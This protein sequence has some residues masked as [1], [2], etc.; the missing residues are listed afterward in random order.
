MIVD[1]LSS[2]IVFIYLC[3]KSYRRPVV[4]FALFFVL[5]F[6]FWRLLS[7]A[8]VSSLE[9]L[10]PTE[11]GNSII[12]YNRYSG[13]AFAACIFITSFAWFWVFSL[14]K[15][16]KSQLPSNTRRFSNQ[17]SKTL[18]E[19]FYLACIFFVIGLFISLF[20]IGIIPLFSGME[21]F[22]YAENHAGILHQFLFSHGRAG[23]F[24]MGAF[25]IRPVLENKMPDGRF[26]FLLGIILFYAFI[27]GHRFSGFFQFISFFILPS[28]LFFLIN[29]ELRKIIIKKIFPYIS[30]LLLVL[31]LTVIY[32]IL[33]SYLNVRVSNAELTGLEALTERLF[34]QPVHLWWATWDRLLDDV[35]QPA[36]AI[37]FI[38]STALVGG[39]NA[40]IQYLMV[41]ELGIDRAEELLLQGTQLQGGYPE[42][43][44]EV[45]GIYYGFIAVFFTALLVAYSAKLIVL[46]FAAG[47]VIATTAALYVFQ[48]ISLVI[49]GGMI[50]FFVAWTYWVKVSALILAMIFE[51]SIYSYNKLKT[52]HQKQ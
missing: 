49:L 42:I 7:S 13:L 8:Y 28:S 26:L 16:G 35:W 32:A 25:F 45:F 10:I 37:T 11:G 2:L 22:E 18:V 17:L 14:G 1:I 30:I 34:V 39:R 20:L 12:I 9:G 47:K 36:F 5:F 33:N 29:K 38:F 6:F 23:I 15:I 50:E 51:P 40:G 24:W 4:F 31:L 44:F 19:V 46:N 27:V 21:R 43:L 48:G 3:I 41:Q 52:E